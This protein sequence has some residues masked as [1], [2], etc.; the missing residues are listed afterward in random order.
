M[1]IVDPDSIS[2]YFERESVKVF[3]AEHVFEHLTH[4][5]AESAL[6]I[7]KDYLIAGGYLRIAVPDGFH[8]DER[9]INQAKP[10]GYGAGAGDHIVLY[11][12]K[13]LRRLIEKVGF[14]SKLLEWYD[15]EGKFHFVDWQPK[16]GFILRS[17]RF[18]ER[19]RSKKLAY[20]SLIIDAIKLS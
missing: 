15:Q 12:Y 16:T 13:T 5:Q 9:Y 4:Q 10:G 7:C 6:A 11:N 14:Q 2:R 19:N 1:D 3:L 18:D 20:T 17:S 8:P